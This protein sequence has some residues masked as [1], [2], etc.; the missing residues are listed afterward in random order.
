MKLLPG[1]KVVRVV[2]SY[3]RKAASA[4]RRQMIAEY[5]KDYMPRT[6]AEVDE[7]AARIDRLRHQMDALCVEVAVR[8]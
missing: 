7:K 8:A 2:P 1:W 4:V 6:R 3:N 5:A